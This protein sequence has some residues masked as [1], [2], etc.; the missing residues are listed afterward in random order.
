[1]GIINDQNPNQHYG[2]KVCILFFIIMLVRSIQCIL[3]DLFEASRGTRRLVG[4][5]RAER[6]ALIAFGAAESR[7]IRAERTRTRA[8]V[9]LLDVRHRRHSNSYRK[10]AQFAVWKECFR[11][12]LN[13]R[14]GRDPLSRYKIWKGGYLKALTFEKTFFDKRSARQPRLRPNW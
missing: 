3:W 6:V 5:W 13:W 12:V 4:G 2:L 10:E 14:R 11:P 1:V 7:R 8:T 9:S